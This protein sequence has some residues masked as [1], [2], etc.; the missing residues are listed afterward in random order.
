MQFSEC[1]FGLRMKMVVDIKLYVDIELLSTALTRNSHNQNSHSYPN[2]HI[3]F[4]LNVTIYAKIG[5]GKD[6]GKTDMKPVFFSTLSHLRVL[7]YYF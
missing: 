3:V 2:S 6:S 4:A 7:F 1:L 5:Y